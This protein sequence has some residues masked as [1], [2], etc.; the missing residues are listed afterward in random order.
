MLEVSLNEIESL[1]LKAARGAGFDW[2]LADEVARAA[3]WLAARDLPWAGSLAAILEVNAAGRLGGFLWT[4]SD[5]ATIAADLDS[6]PIRGGACLCD[7]VRVLPRLSLPRTLQPLWLLPFA[8]TASNLTGV[9][10]G[11][12]WS[13]RHMVVGPDGAFRAFAQSMQ[14]LSTVSRA[15]LTIEMEPGEASGLPLERWATGAASRTVSR[16][17]WRRLQHF[18]HLTYVPASE[19]SRLTGAGAGTKDGD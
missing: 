16:S 19:T 8:D 15:D 4:G 9:P 3:R 13:E 5:I 12:R 6:C 11:L 1:A 18:E 14:H 10:I 17:D 2:G 7:F